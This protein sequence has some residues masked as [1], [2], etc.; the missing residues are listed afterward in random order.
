MRVL[1]HIGTHK[2]ATTHLQQTLKRNRDELSKAGISY[3]SLRLIDAGDSAGH[4]RL[5]HDLASDD[6]ARWD[7][8]SKFYNLA[9]SNSQG[10]TLLLSSEGF[11][12]HKL[13]RSD[14]E[15]AWEQ[16]ANYLD[17]VRDTFGEDCE[18]V[19]VIRRPDNFC[20][21]VYQE[22]T[23]KTSKTITFDDYASR[24]AL[25]FDYNRQA[26]LLSS[27]F[28]KVH[29]LVFEDL[30]ATGNAP[31]AFLNALG[32]EITGLNMVELPRAN[33]GLH[34]LLVE[35]K[36]L[37][38]CFGL[39]HDQSAILVRALQNAQKNKAFEFLETPMSF[40]DFDERQSFCARYADGL[41]SIKSK[42]FPDRTQS[43]F[44]EIK[45]KDETK[46]DGL[47]PKNYEE[48]LAYLMR[49]HD[50]D[51]TIAPRSDITEH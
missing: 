27:R 19:M 2:T 34:T 25:L 24:S 20:L 46:F 3:P 1:L 47:S 18:I 42:F 4:H 41:Q 32:L 30:V 31:E 9:K 49:D 23:K 13:R 48:I 10:G 11:Y 8:V 45:R 50:I 29:M 12:R 14:A 33:E 51:L 16:R 28:T 7:A 36:R 38:N 40:L 17:R 15:G 22:S 43:L 5:A 37:M 21:S 35:F 6:A 26:E 44:P 39:S